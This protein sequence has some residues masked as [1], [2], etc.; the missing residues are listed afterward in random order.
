MTSSVSG[1]NKGAGAIREE[2]TTK[3]VRQINRRLSDREGGDKSKMTQGF[4]ADQE[5]KKHCKWH[6]GGSGQG[7]CEEP[8]S[9]LME[10]C[11]EKWN[12]QVWVC[13]RAQNL[14]YGQNWEPPDF[15]GEVLT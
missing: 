12:L 6:T 9:I 2:M 1:S 5:S 14:Y 15:Y 3:G 8:A 13:E 11:V 10:M 7:Q 4:Y